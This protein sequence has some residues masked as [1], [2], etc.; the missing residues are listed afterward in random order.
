[1]FCFVFNYFIFSFKL[2]FKVT[3]SLWDFHT[4]FSFRFTFANHPFSSPFLSLSLSFFS[5]CKLLIP[6]SSFTLLSLPP[7]SLTQVSWVSF[8]FLC[9]LL[10]PGYTYVTDKGIFRV[11]TYDICLSEHIILLTEDFPIPW[12]LKKFK[13]HVSLGRRFHCTSNLF[14]FLKFN[15][16]IFIL[17]Y[18][19]VYPHTTYLSND[20][21]GYSKTLDALEFQM[22]MNL[23]WTP[24]SGRKSRTYNF[25]AI[26]PDYLY[27]FGNS[28]FMFH[29]LVGNFC[30]AFLFIYF[31]FKFLVICTF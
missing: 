2:P 18:M 21:G 29:L 6:L 27:F 3:V 23:L 8:Y 1:M 17:F 19:R 30:S 9:P 7:P 14:F 10:S 20:H 11:R 26:S 5:C 22:I 31:M 15:N 4:Y 25:W 24:V 16:Y 12:I 13:F 28:M